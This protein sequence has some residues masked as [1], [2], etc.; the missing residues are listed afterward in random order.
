M[1]ALLREFDSA[2]PLDKYLGTEDEL[3]RAR[4]V[5]VSF[6]EGVDNNPYLSSIGRFLLKKLALDILKN[7]KKVLHYYHSNKEFIESNGKLK[8]PVIITGSPRS[9]TTLLQRL[10]SEDPNTRSPYA[11]EMDIAIPPMT[12]D[13]DPLEDPR[14][15][16]SGAAITTLTRLAPGF[17]EKFAESHYVSATE[18]EDPFFYMLAHNGIFETNIAS[19]GRAY[20]D[21][22]LK[23]EDKRPV[24]RYERIF[25]TMLDAYRPAKSHWTFK[26]LDYAHYFPIIFEEYPDVR[27][28]VTHRNPLVTLPSFC[29]LMESWCIAFDQDGTFDKH[30]FGQFQQVYIEKCLMVPLNYRKEHPE[31]EEQIF[32]CMYEELFSDPIAMV[33]RIYHK[34]G[35][36]YTEEYEERMRVYLENNKQGK[37]GRHKYSLDEYGF[38]GESIYQE[39]R[40]YMEQYDFGILDKIERPISFDFSL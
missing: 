5:V 25:F 31:K 17:L 29:R 36:E 10:M 16:S 32:D 3:K 6:C 30:R 21:D 20:I 37:Y 9:G 8:A 7:R 14:I 24:F 27:I 4:M 34:F 2:A 13:A 39:Y 1:D 23:I 11:F 26:S 28:V 12:S 22:F 40:D 38:K 35:L 33:K 18:M 19:A 15:K